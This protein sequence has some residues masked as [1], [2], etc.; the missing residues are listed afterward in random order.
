MLFESPHVIL[1]GPRPGSIGSL[2]YGPAQTVKGQ[3]IVYVLEL[4]WFSKPRIRGLDEPAMPPSPTSDYISGCMDAI[5]A[6]TALWRREEEGG[7]WIG[8][9]QPELVRHFMLG[10]RLD[11]NDEEENPS[12]NMVIYLL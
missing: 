7:I 1:D 10:L 8:N 9:S 3:H 2:V 12:K 5:A 6:L 4:L 11:H